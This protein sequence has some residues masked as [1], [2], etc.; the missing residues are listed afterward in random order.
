MKQPPTIVVQLV[1]IEGP[2]KGE[3][4]DYP[5]PEIAIGRHPSCDVRYPKDLAVVSRQ[6]ARIV[7]EGNRFKI[8]DQSANGTFLNGKAI[9]EAYLKDGDVLMFSEGGPKLSF[10]TQMAAQTA[11]APVM[12]T[13]PTP[14]Q[15]PPS[16]P[17]RAY[18]SPVRPEPA[19]PSPRKPI[20]E[21]AYSRPP[22]PIQPAPASSFG[23]GAPEQISVQRIK[24]PLIIQ[25]GPTLRS[26]NELPVTIGQAPQC[27]FVLNHPSIFERHAQIFFY[28]EQYWIKDLSGKNP[29][30]ING[31]PVD[32]E[33]MLEPDCRL[34]LSPK[35][36][37]FRF[38]GGG[39]LA[40]IEVV[41]EETP[42]QIDGKNMPGRQKGL[43]P[44][45][46]LKDI[47]GM[48]KRF[49]KK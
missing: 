22:A 17:Q 41:P 8:I 16:E 9:T 43:S 26:Y 14:S 29:I 19:V 48:M 7:R 28:Q 36:P 24:K 12:E 35:G 34:S 37:E 31:R 39:R 20:S 11:G 13:M 38:L 27:D 45:N 4:Q 10:L 33:G 18:V 6:H 46:G 1:H 47:G 30:L 25:Y 3:I 2:L 40:E 21:D 23:G 44:S 5:M 42:E 32:R 15:E 49:F